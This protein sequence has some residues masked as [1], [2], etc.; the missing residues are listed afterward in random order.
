MRHA[1]ILC[2]MVPT[3]VL[4]QATPTAV[5]GWQTAVRVLDRYAAADSI[6]GAA[7]ILV[8]DGRTVEQHYSGW[9][10]RDRAE[11][12]EARTIWHWGSITKTLTA[13]ALMQLVERG[14][15][16]LDD[17]V[18]KWVPEVRRV[19]NPFGSMDQVTVRMLLAHNSGLQSGTWPWSRGEAW[20]PFEP[21]EWAQ[22]VAMMPYMKLAFVP[23]ERY[24]YSNPGFVYAARIIETISGDP[25]Q[26][27]IQKN[28]FAPL[29][30]TTSYFGRTPWHLER[31]R[32]NNYEVS[33][34]NVM[35]PG[36][37]D[38][39]PGIT[40]P[41][42][43]WNAPVGD[44]AAWAA[45]LTGATSDSAGGGVLPRK[46][47]ESMWQPVVQAGE[48]WMGLSFFTSRAGA[49]RIIGHTGTQ[50][51]FRSFMYFSPDTRRA[52]I[53]VVNTSNRAQ[54]GKS[55]AGFQQWM[56]EAIAV[57]VE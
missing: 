36:G 19:H 13:V 25:W 29:G 22:L 14:M 23:G 46:R 5:D 6:V 28:I 42:G 9:G 24:Q 12:A 10:D 45:F 31:W 38:F 52:I 48:E 57:L 41:N 8:Q 56:K 7:M 50:A 2:L 4:A 17:P 37:R 39:D 44:L 26:G 32:S 51:N 1:L 40:I 43:G 54:P 16:S 20:E 53:G 21:T 55:Q 3:V 35:V 49:S 15:L 18:S 47:L 34:E 30:I 33:R 27:Y 11:S